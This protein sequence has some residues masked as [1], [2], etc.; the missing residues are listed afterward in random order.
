MRSLLKRGGIVLAASFVLAV[1]ALAS[2]PTPD[3]PAGR[4]GDILGIVPSFGASHNAAG[5]GAGGNLAYHNGPVM[6][7]NATYAIYWVPSGFTIQSGYDSLINQFLGDVAADSGKTTN[8]YYSDTQYYD[9]SGSIAYSSSFKGSATDTSAL[10]ANGCTDSYTKVCLSDAQIRA[11]IDKVAAAQGWP[12][13]GALFFMFTAKGIGSCYSSSS[14]SFSQ[15]CAY[16]SNFSS[17]S[18]NTLYANMPYADTV[19]AA[20]DAGNHPNGNDAD[21]TISVSSHEHNEAIT[22]ALGTAWYDRRGYENGDKCAWN[23]GT[24]LGGGSG[25]QYNQVINGHDY[26]L[27]QEWSNK[28]SGCVLKGL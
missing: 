21:A 27:Q 13:T 24:Q 17:S 7:T 15:Y 12:R 26:E 22:D 14:C 11:E 1:P 5:G 3:N 10:P 9:T 19:P 8:V 28:S 2:A 18:G 20:C 25:A 4:S 6:H 23:F 16:H